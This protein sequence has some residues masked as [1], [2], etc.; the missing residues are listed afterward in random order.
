[1]PVW[2]PVTPEMGKPSF[3]G[4]ECIKEI[5]LKSD[6]K[7][8][9]SKFFTKVK[10]GT[11]SDLEPEIKRRGSD[12]ASGATCEGF[13]VEFDAD[14][15]K[16]VSIISKAGENDVKSEASLVIDRDEKRGV[17]RDHKEFATGFGF[18]TKEPPLQ[19]SAQRKGNNKNAEDKQTTLLSFFGKC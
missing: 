10:T 1:M 11:R 6:D 9:M 16:E 4:P 14:E 2:H 7:N 15:K 13:K 19:S 8:Q 5:Q 17:K 3:N 12:L 18:P